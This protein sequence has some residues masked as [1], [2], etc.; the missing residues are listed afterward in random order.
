MSI[1]YGIFSGGL[2]SLLA[3]RLLMDQGIETR[4]LTFVTPFFGG[5][6]AVASSRLINLET[7]LVDIT[8]VHLAMVQNPRHGYGRFANPCIDCHALMFNQAGRIMT[9]EGGDFLFSGE[10]LGQRPKSQNIQALGLVAR[11]SGYAGYIVRP[12]SALRLPATRVEEAGLVDRDRLLGLSGRSRK[13]Q[14]ELAAGYGLTSY[15]SPA[16]G[17]LL[18]DPIFSRRFKELMARSAPVTARDAELLK[19]GRHFRLP[20]GAKIIVGRNQK[21]NEII[22]GLAGP[23]DTVFK[24]A[25][26]PGPTVVMPGGGVDDLSLAAAITASYSDIRPGETCL[27]RVIQGGEEKTVHARSQDKVE[28]SSLMIK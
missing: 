13:P 8:E 1:A 24:S 17:C 6:K 10:V 27:V 3:A 11:D 4:L 14:M 26:L 5:D 7:R 2:D 12:L 16:G 15:P 25:G 18:T 28:F 21:E 20:G 22:Q 9:G 19:T 23:G